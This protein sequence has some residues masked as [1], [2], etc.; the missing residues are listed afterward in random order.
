MDI[1]VSLFA[2]YICL[3]LAMGISSAIGILYKANI[4]AREITPNTTKVDKYPITSYIFWILMIT[5]IFPLV[6]YRIIT[7][8]TDEL[9]GTMASGLVEE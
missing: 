9:I 2:Y 8:D 7:E 3:A 4:I 1:A 5:S 6:L